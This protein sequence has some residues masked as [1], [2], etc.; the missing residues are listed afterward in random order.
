MTVKGLLRDLLPPL[1]LRMLKPVKPAPAPART[2]GEATD[3]RVKSGPLSGI[4]L[5]VNAAQP[6]FREMVDGTF[7][8][9]LWDATP[10]SLD[11][12]LILDIGAHVGYH[13]LG[14]AA[15]YP[16]CSV[17]AFE[18]NPANQDRLRQHL[19][20][21]PSVAPRIAL[22][23]L[24]LSDVEGTLTFMSSANVEDQTSSGGYLQR[25]SP[26]LDQATYD[27]AGFARSEVPS[28]RLDD[29]VNE[30]T[31][32]DIRMIKLDVEGAE[33]L[34]LAGAMETLRRDRPLLLIEVHSVACMLYVLE[35]LH[36]LG[37]STRLL[38]EDDAFRCFIG[39]LPAPP[40]D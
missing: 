28:R 18:P 37:Y 16:A 22:Q 13:T 2:F 10:V 4:T 19:A 30:H 29:L 36:P 40:K 26:P 17:V 12:G 33:H 23:S 32:T 1:L 39:A 21:N 38:H 3:H 5:R 15:R 8:D 31:W 27:R 35:L 20:L 9:F 14:F 7:D 24:A 11:G 6:A 34:V 25:G